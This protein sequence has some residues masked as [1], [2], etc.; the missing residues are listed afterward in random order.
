MPIGGILSENSA[1]FHYLQRQYALSQIISSYFRYLSP[2]MIPSSDDRTIDGEVWSK[3]LKVNRYLGG[4]TEIGLVNSDG[5]PGTD[6]HEFINGAYSMLYMSNDKNSAATYSSFIGQ[7]TADSISALANGNLTLAMREIKNFIAANNKDLANTLRSIGESNFYYDNIEILNSSIATGSAVDATAA[8]QLAGLFSGLGGYTFADIGIAN[9]ALFNN[10]E[11]RID[12]AIQR[13]LNNNTLAN[14]DYS[15]IDNN[16]KIRSSF[17]ISP[18]AALKIGCFIDELQSCL[19]LKVGCTQLSGYILPIN[20]F[21]TIT[22]NKFKKIT[23]FFAIGLGKNLNKHCGIS[24]EIFK[25][26]KTD[27]NLTITTPYGSVIN[28]K[29]KI[30]KVNIAII[31]FY[32]L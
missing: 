13:A 6:I 22:N 11:E 20:N 27:K 24:I 10:S 1:G 26:K 32:R 14:V 7:S 19:Y 15:Y 4:A 30:D 23:P 21:Y 18:Y 3:F 2:Y 29:A 9:T 5:T 17:N 28:N 12:H 16:I 25:A 31:L 8:A